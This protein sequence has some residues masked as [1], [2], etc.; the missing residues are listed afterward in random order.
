MTVTDLIDC[1]RVSFAFLVVFGAV[2]CLVARIWPGDQNLLSFCAI[3]VR[4]SLFAAVAAL[5]LGSMRICLPGSMLA[6]YLVLF[7]MLLWLA[8][9][10]EPLRQPQ[11]RAALLHKL[12][13]FIENR[14]GA[15]R[16]FNIASSDRFRHW[17]VVREPAFLFSMFVAVAALSHSLQY[18]RFLNDQS[19][20]RALSLQKLALGQPWT[21]DGSVAFLAPVVFLSSLDG[22]TVVRFSGPLFMAV[23]ALTGFAAIRGATGSSPVG[24]AAAAV[25]VTLTVFSHSA[26]L[27][28]GGMALIFW[29]IGFSLWARYRWDALWSVA[30]AMLIEPIPEL[31]TVLCVSVMLA[32]AFLARCGKA[33][34]RL[35]QAIGTPLTV[36]AIACLILIPLHRGKTHGSQYNITART[37]TRIIR[38]LPRNTWL[39]VSPVQEVALTYGHGWHMELSEFVEKYTVDEVRRPDFSFRFPVVDTFVFVEKQPLTSR[40]MASGLSELGP[41][42]D[43]PMAPYQLRLN[44]ASLQFQAAR[45]LAAY[46]ATHSGTEVFLEDQHLIVYRIRG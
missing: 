20:S 35:F 10:L 38:E 1:L 25:L 29:L 32:I 2:P 28:A 9:S 34:Q 40:A 24:L 37:V 42:F 30:L 41:H 27:Q 22:A 45:L 19:Y 12:V 18:V 36:A 11:W 16:R 6:A 13:V 43:P 5:L 7:L 23:L 31:N 3:A 26:E 15:P 8:G 21:S 44:R 46:R 4:T 39:V 17:R 33:T 14:H